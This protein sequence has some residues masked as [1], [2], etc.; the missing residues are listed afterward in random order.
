VLRPVFA[1]TA[2]SLVAR[3]GGE[4]VLDVRLGPGARNECSADCRDVG[5]TQIDDRTERRTVEDN[6]SEER[7]PTAAELLAWRHDDVFLP[8]AEAT[9]AE[10]L[11]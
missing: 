5:M 1:P 2:S 4:G 7:E 3:I 8:D 9:G 11:V 10:L 6:V